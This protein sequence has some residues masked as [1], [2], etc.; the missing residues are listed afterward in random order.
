VLFIIQVAAVSCA[1]TQIP[2]VTVA[3]QSF[4]NAGFCKA[5][6]LE[7]LA[8][9]ILI[10]QTDVEADG[11]LSKRETVMAQPIRGCRPTPVS[12]SPQGIGNGEDNG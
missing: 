3:N 1:E 8:S 12:A 5:T 4:L 11:S 2:E 9:D 6:Q 10:R 7:V